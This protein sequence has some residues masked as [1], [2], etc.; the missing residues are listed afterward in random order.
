MRH[1]LTNISIFFAVIPL[2][3]GGFSV[4]STDVSTI[5]PHLSGEGF[6]ISAD[7]SPTEEVKKTRESDTEAQIRAWVEELEEYESNIVKDKD[8]YKRIDVNGYY[9]YSCLQFQMKTYLHF[10]NLKNDTDL[11]LYENISLKEA[12]KLITDCE[13]QKELAVW[14]IKENPQRWKHW[15]Y[16]VQRGL[17]LPPNSN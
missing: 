11:K 13:R 14:M 15:R 12:R 3:W 9:S 16:S 2:I 4:Q 8:N 1:Q 5:P 7:K 6:H 17:G 10:Y